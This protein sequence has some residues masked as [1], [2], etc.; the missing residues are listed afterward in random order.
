MQVRRKRRNIQGRYD[1][2]RSVITEK[3]TSKEVPF[4]ENGL[5]NLSFVDYQDLSM[6][7][8]SLGYNYCVM[9]NSL[10]SAS[11]L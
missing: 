6:A 10:I 1:E 5:I 2:L 7:H 8:A 11:C 9:S 3:I 4:E